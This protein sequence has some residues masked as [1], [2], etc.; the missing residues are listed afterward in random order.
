MRSNLRRQLL[1]LLM[2]GC[3][4]KLLLLSRRLL[5]VWWGQLLFK[6]WCCR[7]AALV[8]VRG[9]AAAQWRLLHDG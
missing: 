6:P 9:L 4:A 7:D 5:P 3:L 8:T 2:R 1:L